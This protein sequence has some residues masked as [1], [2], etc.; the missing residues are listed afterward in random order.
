MK[1]NKSNYGTR[2]GYKAKPVRKDYV[3]RNGR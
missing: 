3:I 2:Y 1:K